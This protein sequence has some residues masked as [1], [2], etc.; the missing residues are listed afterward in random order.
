MIKLSIIVPI[1]NAQNHLKK[2]I[3]SIMNQTEKDIEI[4]LIDDGSTD[5]SLKICNEYQRKDFRI[6]VIHQK[7]SGVSIAR[8]QGIKIA[9]G[10]Y[11]GFVD[12][13]DWIDL[14]MFKRLL[15]EAKKT[16]ADIVMCDATTVY[17]TGEKQEDTI[18][19]LA[20]NRILDKSDFTPALL[21]E[22]AGSV[23][24]CIYKNNNYR[25][26]PIKSNKFYFPLGIKFSE[27]RIYNI[28]AFGYAN[29][30]DY[31]KESYYNRYMNE[32]SAVHRFHG[33]YFEAYKKSANEIEKAIY[34]AWN[35]DQC[36][37]TAYLKQLITG[38]IM[39]ICNYYYK[40][41]TLD[42]FQKRTAV[43][44]LCDDQMLR[45]A[46]EKTGFIN[47]QAKWIVNKKIN[48]LILYAKIANLKHN[49]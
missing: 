17:S 21:L 49:R 42:C 19:Q 33:D 3:E 16:D 18:T 7:N 39:A 37:Q 48:L 15:E 29:K 8:N 44:K 6:N 45:N 38:S 26:K 46:I 11:I 14:D 4:I 20:T 43:K 1:Y 30:I 35:N 5:D 12:S 31:I 23:W 47:K 10:E 2:C 28:Y 25:D 9:K 40:T 34:L 32:K 24:R 41:S 13:D 27:D 22:M 36:Y